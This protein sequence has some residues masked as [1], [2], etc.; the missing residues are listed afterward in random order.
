MALGQV[1]GKGLLH[2][3]MR[4]LNGEEL[5]MARGVNESILSGYC[6]FGLGS[7]NKQ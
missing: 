5:L 7:F 4:N 1:D 3:L 2:Y 6:L